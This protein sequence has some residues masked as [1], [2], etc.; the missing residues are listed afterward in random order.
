[1]IWFN[2]CRAI[3]LSTGSPGSPVRFDNNTPAFIRDNDITGTNSYIT[4]SNILSAVNKVTVSMFLTH[5][6]D[7]DIY[8]E[9]F[10][11]D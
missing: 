6:F 7:S 10:G 1:M 8:F 5:S 4:V 11:R 2:P 9:L 3:V